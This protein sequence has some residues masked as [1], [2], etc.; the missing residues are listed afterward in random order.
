MTTM[1]I[2]RSVLAITIAVAVESLLSGCA[3]SSRP[4]ATSAGAPKP[5]AGPPVTLAL[6]ENTTAALA[7]TRDAYIAQACAGAHGD[8]QVAALFEKACRAGDGDGCTKL[9]VI[10]MCGAGVAKDVKAAMSMFENACALSNEDGCQHQAFGLIGDHLGRRDLP[11]GIALFDRRCSKGSARACASLATILS[12]FPEKA[13]PALT[14][15]DKACTLGQDDAC[16]NVAVIEVNGLG[17]HKPNPE[18][19]LKFA[20]VACDRK[21]AFACGILGMMYVRGMGVAEDAIAGV[22]LLT[23]SC[24]ANEPAGCGYLAV[25]YYEGR[26]VARDEAKAAELFR[27]ACDGGNGQACRALGELATPDSNKQA[28]PTR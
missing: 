12:V 17:D 15:F 14:Y 24:E 27:K 16:A 5:Q 2:D 26:G 11:R 28:A 22:K 7:P 18:R 6:D 1:R 23:S 13:T 20:K 25:C 3:H 21:N 19:A 10:D 9:G 4:D 8:P